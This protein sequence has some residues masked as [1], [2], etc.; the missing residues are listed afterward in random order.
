[1]GTQR[2]LRVRD[3]WTFGRQSYYNI[4]KLFLLRNQADSLNKCIIK[5]SQNR[6]QLHVS[7]LVLLFLH[8]SPPQH[9]RPQPSS[10]L[11]AAW[12]RFYDAVYRSRL[13]HSRE[14]VRERFSTR[15]CGIYTKIANGSSKRNL[16]GPYLRLI[17]TIPPRERERKEQEE[18][19]N[20]SS[21]SAVEMLKERK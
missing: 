2:I 14:S 17:R 1:M 5:Q 7:F 18:S 20:S 21:S 10:L 6:Q 12:I 9:P 4:Y 16:G 19:S 15:L 11:S 8:P 13:R 3:T